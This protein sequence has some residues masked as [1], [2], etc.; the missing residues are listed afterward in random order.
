MMLF[1]S[2]WQALAFGAITTVGMLIIA[3]FFTIMWKK[4]EDVE[5]THV[6]KS[7]DAHHH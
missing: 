7:C 3:N 4:Y 1:Q 5:D 2:W 6:A